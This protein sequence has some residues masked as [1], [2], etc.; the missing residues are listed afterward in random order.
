MLLPR[1][2]RNGQQLPPEVSFSVDASRIVAS[3]LLA[4][5]RLETT[6]N[7]AFLTPDALNQTAAD[8]TVLVSCW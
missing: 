3:L 6:E 4:D 7:V 8:M 2:S 5:V 1:A